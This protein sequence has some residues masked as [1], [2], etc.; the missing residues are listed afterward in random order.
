MA[1][2]ALTGSRIRARRLDMGL[3]QAALAETVGIS[4]SYL[5]LIEHNRRRIGGALLSRIAEA[6]GLDPAALMEGAATGQVAALVEAARAEPDGAAEIDRAEEFLSRFPGWAALIAAQATRIGALERQLETLT[7]R[8]GSDPR[9]AGSVHEI[10]TAVTAIRS[11]A[12]IL[13]QDPG[14]DPDWQKRFHDNLFADAVRLA[15]TSTELTALLQAG[16]NAAGGQ[17]LSPA[18]EVERWL[19]ADPGWRTAIE[20]GARSIP[21]LLEQAALSDGA[22]ELATARLAQFSEDAALLPF[23]PFAEAVEDCGEDLVAV[24][25]RLGAPLVRVL[26]RRAVLPTGPGALGP[27][28]LIEA[29]GA[30]RVLL[31]LPVPGRS[32]PPGGPT[33]A[34]WPL[35]GALSQPGRPV[36]RHLRLAGDAPS[37]AIEATAVADPLEPAPLER[38]PAVR[39]VMVL[40]PV[41][42]TADGPRP[43]EVG[44]G[45]RVCPRADCPARS[46]PSI[47]PQPSD[48]VAF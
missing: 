39:S 25:V 8:F 34:L 31:H 4:A 35:Y 13:A 47:L 23:A 48:R 12:S 21:D 19:L 17:A 15:E 22:R 38:P 9:L 41:T 40:R 5:N 7:D 18:E 45:C 36:R 30:G 24:A 43:A 28:G 44:T 10:L 37:A 42:A 32:L 16:E 26:R 29:D 11:T 20:D 1:G 33:C 27:V 46:V 2:P 14:L 3:R 6:L